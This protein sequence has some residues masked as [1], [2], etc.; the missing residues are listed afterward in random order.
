MLQTALTKLLSAYTH[1]RW[2]IP[3]IIVILTLATALRMHLLGTVPHGITWD[4]AAIGYNGYAVITTRRDEWL[5][6]LPISFQSFG[7]YK[8]PFAIYLVGIFVTLFELTPFVVRL[9]FALAGIASVL[10]MLLVVRKLFADHHYRDHYSLV[11][12]AILAF[13][14][15]H[16]HFSRTAFE[17][18][19]TLCFLIWGIWAFYQAMEQNRW[20]KTHLL[21]SVF[22]FSLSLYTYHS[23]KIVAPLL[24]V[25]LI[26][27]QYKK[28]QALP[29]KTTLTGATFGLFLTL[30]LI[31]DA[32]WG[33]GL[34][35]AAVTLFAQAESTTELVKA[36]VYNI[37]SHLSPQFLL[38]ANTTTL[39]HSAGLLGVLLPTTAFCVVIATYVT[40][41]KKSHAGSKFAL[42]GAIIG[43]LPAII[44]T[45][46]PHPNR[47][48]LSLPFLILLAIYGLDYSISWIRNT[49]LNQTIIGSHQE[50]N[51]VLKSTL[52]TMALLH[53]LFATAF[54]QHYFTAFARSSAEAFSDGYIETITLVEKLKQDDPTIEKI[55]FTSDYGQ[56]Y[57]YAL[58]VKKTNPIWYQG[59][60]LNYY[61]FQDEIN[62]ADLSR[63]RSIIV[64]SKTDDLPIE[65]ADHVILGSDQL[66]RF[67]VFIT[68]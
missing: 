24:A 57:I 28:M 17:S 60:S 37:A 38:F 30:P 9:P 12:A 18:G 19:L 65:R 31:I 41:L 29:I 49:Q 64:G 59:G 40:I 63:P 32:F 50:K 14:P 23:A 52:G 45:E 26:V 25:Y 20:T 21:L 6:R 67:Q 7:D 58:F 10:G 1:N 62:I 34:T 46:A 55:V 56:P 22:L 53:V 36:L 13:S 27:A 43:M 15:W 39:R 42:F 11:A 47:A 16:L 5:H 68:Q 33:R 4:E 54:I 61:Q 44:A 8:A 2:F 3:S 48:L 66:P 35:R 51:I